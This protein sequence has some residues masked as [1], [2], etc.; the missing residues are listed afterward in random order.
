MATEHLLKTPTRD[1]V[2]MR[3]AR[4]S[5]FTLTLASIMTKEDQEVYKKGLREGSEKKIKL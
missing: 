1:I 4:V 5:E 3:D 2:N